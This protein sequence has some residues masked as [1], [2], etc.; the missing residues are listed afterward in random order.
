ML[1]SNEWAR[2]AHWRLGDKQIS[3]R[4]AWWV[5]NV[6]CLCPP[7]AQ[8]CILTPTV[9]VLG[10]KAPGMWL[11]QEWGN[12]PEWGNCFIRRGAESFL[13]ISPSPPHPPQKGTG[14]RQL[15]TNQEGLQQGLCQA[16][17]LLSDCR[18]TGNGCLFFKP[19]FCGPPLEQLGQTKRE[20]GRPSEAETRCLSFYLCQ[21]ERQLPMYSN[22]NLAN[23]KVTD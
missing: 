6:E 8:I 9:M 2:R 5:V 12:P 17:S 13:L 11:I 20:N 7:P 14:R 16:G 15:S 10:G 1:A 18:A 3:V 22:E 4:Q 19:P 21:H 23:G